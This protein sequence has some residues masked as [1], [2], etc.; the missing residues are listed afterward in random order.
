MTNFDAQSRPL[1]SRGTANA[2][3][4][5][6]QVRILVI[7]SS[8]FL[9]LYLLAGCSVKGSHVWSYTIA[10]GDCFVARTLRHD[11]FLSSL[12]ALQTARA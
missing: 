12:M 11:L 6:V 10:Q 8:P 9:S 2:V 3:G 1:V 4:A 5:Q 7:V